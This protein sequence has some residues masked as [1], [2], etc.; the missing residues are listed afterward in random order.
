[1][2]NGYASIHVLMDA[3]KVVQGHNGDFDWA[4]NPIIANINKLVLNFA[5]VRVLFNL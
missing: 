4:I 1:M 3:K 2:E 5:H